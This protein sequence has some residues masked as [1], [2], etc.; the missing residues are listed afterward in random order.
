MAEAGPPGPPKHNL[1]Q[2]IELTQRA[3]AHDPA[4]PR[5]LQMQGPDLLGSIAVGVGVGVRC[6]GVDVEWQSE[7][8]PL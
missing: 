8:V 4:P 2:Q 5:P 3:R 1:F 6:V 7:R